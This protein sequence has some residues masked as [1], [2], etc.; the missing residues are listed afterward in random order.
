MTRTTLPNTIRL[1]IGLLAVCSCAAALAQPST[2][3]QQRP[4]MQ[5]IG[6]LDANLDRDQR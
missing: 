5:W 4:G 6:D 2:Q 1:T 3:P